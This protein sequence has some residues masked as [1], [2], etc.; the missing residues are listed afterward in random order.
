MNRRNIIEKNGDDR[1]SFTNAYKVF[2]DFARELGSS[3]INEVQEA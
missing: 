3:R 2:I 1:F